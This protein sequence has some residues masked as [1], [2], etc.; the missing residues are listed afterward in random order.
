ML[1]HIVIV[2]VAK[3]SAVVAAATQEQVEE[4]VG[5]NIVPYPSAPRHLEIHLVH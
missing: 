2:R 5:V 3:T 1:D 4:I